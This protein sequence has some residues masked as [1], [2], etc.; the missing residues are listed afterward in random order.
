MGLALARQ[1]SHFILKL[2]QCHFHPHYFQNAIKQDI[3]NNLRC[4]GNGTVKGMT[5]FMIVQF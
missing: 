3:K 2:V 4:R 1:V 5:E